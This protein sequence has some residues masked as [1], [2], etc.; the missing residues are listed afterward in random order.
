MD[1][2]TVLKRAAEKS[3]VV[4]FKYKDRDVPTSV[5]SVTVLPFFGDR[6]S[7]FVLSS[8]LISRIKQELKGSRY[9]ILIS[10]PGD[11]ALYPEVDEYWQLEDPAALHRAAAD[12]FGFFNSASFLPIMHRSLNQYF[13]DVM[14]ERDLLPFYDNGLTAGFFERFRHVKVRL[15][16]VPSAS[17]L[18][19]EV[20]RTLARR[21]DKVFLMPSKSIMSWRGGS[22]TR[23]PVQK[24]FWLS[25]LERLVSEGFYP[26]VRRDL[27]SYDLS[28]D[29]TDSCLHLDVADTLKSMSAMRACGC[30]LDFFDGS[31]R[32]ALAARCPFL[33][34]DER[35]R[36]NATKDYELN[37]L[38]G[39]GIPKEY[40]FS[41][42]ALVEKGNPSVWK[43]NLFDHMSVK[44]RSMHSR[45]DRDSWPAAVETNEIVP[46]DSVRKRK[47]K[48]LGS[49]F[50]K[51]ERD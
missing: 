21:E 22:C 19:A 3:G 37:D 10:W 32:L 20:S 27:F 24:E 45:E 5:E 28:S 25:L 16:S 1:V 43:T 17:S 11:D 44:L 35:Q 31:S 38:C 14:S 49:R 39:S 29:F 13:Y 8:L 12:S 18:G 30:V 46:Y 41:F 6:R 4:R 36:F 42:A 26:V 48:R 34:F 7:S 23:V 47:L 50:I 33:C 15:P 40:I 9:F 51:I 2:C